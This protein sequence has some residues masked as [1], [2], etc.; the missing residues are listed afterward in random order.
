VAAP[1]L[2]LPDQLVD[3][4]EEVVATQDHRAEH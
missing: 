4:L 3:L 2:G 1:V